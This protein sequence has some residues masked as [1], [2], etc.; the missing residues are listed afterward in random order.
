[1]LCCYQFLTTYIGGDL[2]VYRCCNTAYTQKGLIGNLRGQRFSDLKPK[3]FLFD[4]RQCKFCQFRGQNKA[5]KA[6]IDEPTHVN[7]V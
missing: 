6:L 2:N 5:I 7:F 1:M 3:L 4:A